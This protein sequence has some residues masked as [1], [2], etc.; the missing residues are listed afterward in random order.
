MSALAANKRPALDAG[1]GVSLQFERQRPGASEAGR[2]CLGS[3]KRARTSILLGFSL[4]L[5]ACGVPHYD[6]VRYQQM[7]QVIIQSTNMLAGISLADASRL[8]NLQG[9]LRDKAY[10]PEPRAE[11][12]F[13]HF[14]GF[15]LGLDLT[16]LPR[17]GDSSPGTG[18]AGE[19]KALWVGS[20][21]P[22]LCIDRLNDPK[23][24]M[25]NYWDNLNAS[26]RRRGAETKVIESRMTAETNK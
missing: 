4:L 25:S 21:W 17:G 13:Y 14:Q 18:D 19:R 12:R 26:F 7:E 10:T 1:T 11:V 5:G 16:T 9:V 2:Y 20:S 15:Y 6:R 24:R 23:I 8:L 3:M 22:Q